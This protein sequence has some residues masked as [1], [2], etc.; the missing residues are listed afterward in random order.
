MVL[1]GRT[2]LDWTH[3]FQNFCE[4]GLEQIQFFR[5]RIGPGLK[6]FTA[7]SFLC[8][9]AEMSVGLDLDWTRTITNFVGFGL[10]P[11]CKSLQK[12]RIRTGSGLS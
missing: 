8:N 4:S 3:D 9:L 7:R 5:I 6:N 10:D 12:F 1:Y 2:G 11:N